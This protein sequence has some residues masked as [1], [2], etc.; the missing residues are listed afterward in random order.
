MRAFASLAAGIALC[1][2]FP[3]TAA[4]ATFTVTSTADSGPGTLRQAILNANA[5]GGLDNIHFNIP[6]TGVHNIALSTTLPGISS[7]V[8]IDG[9]TQPGASANT[10]GL[11]S[12]AVILID[13]HPATA[14]GTSGIGFLNGS[15]G[16]SVRGLALN[17]FA[18]S[19]LNFT[20]NATNCIVTGNFIGLAADGDTMYPSTPGSRTGIAVGASGCRI[21][22]STPAERNVISGNSNSGIY[23]GAN[24]VEIAGNVIGADRTGASARP[25]SS[26]IRLGFGQ[27]TII[28]ADNASRNVISG[29]SRW[30]IEIESADHAHIRVNTIG[31]TAFP[32]IALPNALGG[33]LVK[34]G[35]DIRI[36]PQVVSPGN[37]GNIIGSN[38]GPGILVNGVDSSV[39]ILGNLIWDNAGLPIDLA[40][41]GENGLDPIDNLDADDG[42]NGLQNRPVITDRDN[43]GATTV[44][45]GTLHSSPSTSFYLDF[46]LATACEPDGHADVTDYLGYVTTTT[47]ANG[48]ASWT[49]NHDSL[50]TGDFIVATAST[51]DATPQ[52]SEFS[53]CLPLAQTDVFADGFESP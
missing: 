22:G 19:Q 36:A 46:Y 2:A 51:S 12:N 41:F 33:I 27:N 20:G 49:Y 44:V 15:S 24:D 53:L 28:G 48:N 31:R 34:D 45:H 3:M 16:S 9:Y 10:S 35:T 23:V 14:G 21:G 42:P 47:A 26:G 8:L 38:G 37:A 6:G 13:I 1:L 50:L 29:N 5:A 4:A 25:N 7:P 11:A 18:N 40:V 43:S 32:I 52:T 30:G 39:N 17:R